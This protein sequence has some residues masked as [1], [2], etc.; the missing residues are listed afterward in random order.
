MPNTS[1]TEARIR[2]LEDLIKALLGRQAS[3]EH[4]LGA[5]VEDQ[6]RTDAQPQTQTIFNCITTG[7]V[8][9]RVGTTMGSGSFQFVDTTGGTMV[10][11]TAPGTFTGYTDSA[12]G[13]DS[14]KYGR[15]TWM[16]EH[17]EFLTADAC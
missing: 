3:T 9:A 16:N 2:R 13:W 14:G 15:V 7:A 17:W 6:S 10:T 5:V 11:L 12:T 4:K 8:S 1:A